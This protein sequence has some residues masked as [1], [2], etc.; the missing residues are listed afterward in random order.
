MERKNA[1]MILRNFYAFVLISVLIAALHLVLISGCR[2]KNENPV[3]AE[4]NQEKIYFADYNEFLKEVPETTKMA[5]AKSPE[6]LLKHLISRKLLVQE[7]ARQGFLNQDAGQDISEPQIVKAVQ[8][9]LASQIGEKLK[10]SENEI[11]AFYHQHKQEFGDKPISEV[12]EPIQRFILTRK[13]QEVLASLLD[14]LYQKADIRIFKENLLQVKVEGLAPSNKEDL[15]K[16]VSSGKPTLVDFSSDR[17]IPCL[18][19]RPVL[20]ALNDKFQGKVNVM[21]IDVTQEKDLSRQY[22][23]RVTPTL[24]FFD[25]K[26]KETGRRM[27]F[28]DQ[29]AIE[30]KMKELGMV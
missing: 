10:V 17:C 7:A 16:A 5:F 14:R 11:A 9:L 2:K 12:K 29:A 28:M 18:Q 15:L 13:Q 1:H 23:I 3:V 6:K 19:L 4:V 26:G 21:M 20:N 8:T 30:K 24:I 22:R 25:A 27:G